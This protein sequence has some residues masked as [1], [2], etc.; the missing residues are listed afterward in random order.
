MGT[1]LKIY[2]L[3]LYQIDGPPSRGFS[4]EREYAMA[5]MKARPVGRVYEWWIDEIM[6]PFTNQK[7]VPAEQPVGDG[8]GEGGHSH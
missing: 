7:Y 2:A 3:A 5:V 1:D 6:Y 4:S 8:H